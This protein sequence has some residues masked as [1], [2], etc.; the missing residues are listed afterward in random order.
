MNYEQAKQKIFNLPW[1]I[2]VCHSGEDCWCRLIRPAEGVEYIRKSNKES[3]ILDCI[4]DWGSIDKETAEYII[5]LHNRHLDKKPPIIREI[6]DYDHKSYEYAQQYSL[7]I[8]WKLDICNVGEECW[9]RMIVPTEK[10]E[11]THKYS[12]GKETTCEIEDIITD[13]A[14]D[15]DIAEYIVNLHN[16]RFENISLDT[17][18]D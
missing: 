8:P 2:D 16:Q 6:Q 9:C 14:I 3:A 18:N 4:I 13:G 17:I 7:N 15:K 5:D 11:Y 10:I 12:S 1:K